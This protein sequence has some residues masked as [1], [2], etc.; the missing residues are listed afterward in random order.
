MMK[1]LLNKFEKS[2]KILAERVS[3]IESNYPK[4]EQ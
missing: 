4:I 1:T 2:I 3:Q